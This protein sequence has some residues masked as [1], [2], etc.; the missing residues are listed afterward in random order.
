MHRKIFELIIPYIEAPKKANVGSVIGFSWD[1]DKCMSNINVFPG[2]MNESLSYYVRPVV[3]LDA[4]HL[5]G[6]HKGTLFVASVLSGGANDVYP[7][8]FMISKGNE[9]ETRG[10]G[11]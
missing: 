2:F 11:C 3:L 5:K 1:Y 10:R 4:A 6:V 8:G 7:I 9:D